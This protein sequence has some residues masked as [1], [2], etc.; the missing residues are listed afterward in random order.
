V[1]KRKNVT[2]PEAGAPKGPPEAPE[3]IPF[4]PQLWFS[5][6]PATPEEAADFKRWNEVW[7]DFFTTGTLEAV[8]K[9]HKRAVPSTVA[10]VYALIRYEEDIGLEGASAK[11]I[12]GYAASH[13]W[14][15][16][17]LINDRSF[18]DLL[19]TAQKALRDSRQT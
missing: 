1:T 15:D 6:N 16:E 17:E 14:P 18:S 13:G 12:R 9:D 4:L 5:R 8:V 10:A 19:T 3:G 7:A 2:E 11:T